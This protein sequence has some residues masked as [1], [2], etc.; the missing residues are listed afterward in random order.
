MAYVA[1]MLT[2][3][4]SPD[5]HN[6]ARDVMA[7]ETAVAKVQWPIEKR[8]EVEANYNPRTKAQLIAYAPGFPWQEFLDAGAARHA[9]GP[10]TRGADGHQGAGRAL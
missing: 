4:G 9:P 6:Q 1:Q 2:L 8:R 10:G 3:G 7:F 5:P